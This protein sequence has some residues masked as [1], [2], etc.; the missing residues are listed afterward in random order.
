[1]N[2]GP[3]LLSV[4]AV[5]AAGALIGASPA[6]AGTPGGTTPPVVDSP[7]SPAPTD[8]PGSPNGT[9]VPGSPDLPGLPDSPGLPD[10]PD[11]PGLPGGPGIPDAP[12]APGVPGGPGVPVPTDTV[13]P[14]DPAETLPGIGFY[15]AAPG[16]V[17]TLL[18]SISG[19]TEVTTYGYRIGD[20]D[21][22]LVPAVGNFATAEVILP[23]G[24]TTVTVRAFNGDTLLGVASTDFTL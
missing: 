12:S 11:A 1:M 14:T 15:L 8:I 16:E 19:T 9:G 2:R 6:V 24:T 17:S 10:L 18:M 23:A 21:E 13:P 22:I 5:I 20:A 3:A 7:A 4:V